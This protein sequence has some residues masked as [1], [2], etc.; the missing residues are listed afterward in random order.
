MQ[1]ASFTDHH[2]FPCS[3]RTRAQ[4]IAHGVVLGGTI[5][6]AGVLFLLSHLGA[7]GGVE[8]WRFWPALLIIAG[9]VQMTRRYRRLPGLALALAG[10]LFLV[11]SLA[12]LPVS[13]GLVWPVLVIGLGLLLIIRVATRRSRVRVP[14]LAGDLPPSSVVMGS[15]EDRVDSRQYEGG[16]VS[17]VMGSYVLDLT[18]AEMKGDTARVT[19]RAIMGAVEIRTPPHWRV[20]VEA[21]PVMGAVE[22]KT[23]EPEDADRT[24]V[25]Q[26]DVV[27]GG[28]EIRN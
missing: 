19:A 24:L 8:A 9:A 27:L 20:Q 10:G 7:L 4:R 14:R 1:Q 3:G 12:L 22:N 13:W 17:T 16:E 11:H 6:A 23:R 21:S 18:R 25:V 2:G 28:V 5:A 26:A 15:R